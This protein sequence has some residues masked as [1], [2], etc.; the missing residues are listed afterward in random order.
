MA[1]TLED[2]K[3]MASE[4]R[5]MPAMDTSKRTLTKQALIK[6]LAREIASLQ[7][8]GYSIEQ[9][10][11]SLRG[12]GLDISTP[13]LKSYLHRSKRRQSKDGARAPRR[14]TTPTIP[15]KPAAQHAALPVT[16]AKSD[17]A[18]PRNGKSAFL[19][20]DKDSY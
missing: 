16:E 1:Y 11:D 10:I 7:Q 15:G 8:R 20:N 4:L 18:A 17:G 19:V 5:A 3:R 13:T 6:H 9:V 12:V 2:A 14:T